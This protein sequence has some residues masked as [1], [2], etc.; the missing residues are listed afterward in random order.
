MDQKSR[1]NV[2]R[3]KEIYHVRELREVRSLA[4]GRTGAGVAKDEEQAQELRRQ[5]QDIRHR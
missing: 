3:R 2:V 5:K 1:T 4:M